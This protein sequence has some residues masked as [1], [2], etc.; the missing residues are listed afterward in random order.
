MLFFSFVLFCVLKVSDAAV[1][2]VF[3]GQASYWSVCSALSPKAFREAAGRR[4]TKRT[5]SV[6]LSVE[7]IYRTSFLGGGG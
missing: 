4:A 1:P 3:R 2:F 7:C 6:V 5:S